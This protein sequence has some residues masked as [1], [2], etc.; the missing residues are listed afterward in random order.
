MCPVV[1]AWEHLCGFSMRTRGSGK[2]G[3]DLG[4]IDCFEM[5]I[6]VLSQGEDAKT[7]GKEKEE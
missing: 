1:L 5:R 4:R 3:E 7:G 2:F 6:D